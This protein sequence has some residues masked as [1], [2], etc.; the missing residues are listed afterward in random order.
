MN[1][2]D[3]FFFNQYLDQGEK[4]IHVIHKHWI[5]IMRRMMQI[6]FF[7]IIIPALAVLFF[8]EPTSIVAYVLYGWIFVGICGSLYTFCNW[9][10]DAWLL[11][12]HSVIDVS[13]DGFFKSSAQRVGYESIESVLYEVSG[14]KGT[15]FNYG[16]LKIQRESGEI[17]ELGDIH[18]P[19]HAEAR[20]NQIHTAVSKK[21]GQKNLEILKELLADVI[22][23]KLNKSGRGR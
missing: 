5:L 11:T 23:D 12:N 14:F 7:G 19:R 6:A 2:Y 9:Y 22:E 16:K 1:F 13:W 21:S 10:S 15:L 17:L 8:F 3:K 4:L 18:K 20:L